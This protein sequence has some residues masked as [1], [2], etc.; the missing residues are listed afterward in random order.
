MMRQLGIAV[1]LTGGFALGL[2]VAGLV[3]VYTYLVG[4]NLTAVVLYGYDK[5]QAVN[6]RCRIRESVLHLL[7]AAGGTPG[8]IV[9]QMLFRHKT[10]DTRFRAV[11]LLIVALA[12][13]A[14]GSL[15]LHSTVTTGLVRMH[16]DVSPEF[17]GVASHDAG[18]IMVER[19]TRTQGRAGASDR[20]TA[21]RIVDEPRG[22]RS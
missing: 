7:A 12:S 3:P 17:N 4:I 21:G 22:E 1:I 2:A 11:F 9:G 18:G 16:V 19:R 10:R 15:P 13:G 5:R 20:G 14:G 8:A 6:H